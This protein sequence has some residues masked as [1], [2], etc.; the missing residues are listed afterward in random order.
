M[1]SRK[2]VV[3]HEEYAVHLA[4]K[5]T[6]E[7]GVVI[8]S[9]GAC[10]C[11]IFALIFCF[12][13]LVMFYQREEVDFAGAFLIVAI[14]MGA[15]SYGFFSLSYIV[16]DKSAKMEAVAPPTRHNI[17]L[18]PASETL[19]RAAQEPSEGQ[20]KILLRAAIAPEETTPEEL[21]RAT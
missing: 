14:A 8:T 19:V 5:T 17:D 7:T 20:E 10:V 16:R 11:L 1:Q 6:L 12:A 13:A 15:M 9:I 21:L 18:L 3:S 2:R 4:R